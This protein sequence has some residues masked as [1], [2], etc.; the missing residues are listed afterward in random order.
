MK[1]IRV[2]INGFGR[3]GRSFFKAAQDHEEID[4][5]AIN[6]LGDIENLAYLLRYD[7][8]YGQAPFVVEV[9][10]GEQPFLI[11][12]GNNVSFVSQKDP[13]LLPWKDM[14]IDIVVESTGFFTSSEKSKAHITA[15]AKRVVITAPLKDAADAHGEG[16]TVLMGINEQDLKSCQ[17]SSNASCTTNAGS[18]VLEIMRNT[19]GVQKA[20]LSTI[21]GYTASQKIVDSPDAKDFRRGRAGAQNL[22]PSSTGAA[23]A[24]TKVV[25][26]LEGLFDGIAVRV[27]VVT[28]SLVDITFLSGRDTSVEEINAIFEKAAKEKRW[29]GIFTATHEP[30]VSSDIIGS[31]YGSIV[32]LGFTK[33]V[34]EN[35]VKVLAWYDN[36]AGYVATLVKHVIK[37]GQLI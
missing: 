27:P 3:I 16:M 13:A 9:K 30:L 24:V 15:G 11:I 5:V 6:D 25:K 23:I 35:L 19:V 17:I 22:I 29:E 14:N 10:K 28:G 31:P 26:E 1:K 21:H 7:T 34:G 8:A 33:V 37:A 4:I 12:N 2:A 36:E 20:L 32:D 18:P